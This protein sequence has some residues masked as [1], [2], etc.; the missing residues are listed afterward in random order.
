M[1]LDL[2]IDNN[3]ENISN[4]QNKKNNLKKILLNK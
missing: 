3:E 2:S 1:G 4:N